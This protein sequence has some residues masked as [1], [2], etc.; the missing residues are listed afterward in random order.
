MLEKLEGPDGQDGPER[1]QREPHLLVSCI[2]SLT[3]TH[4]TLY[5]SV[6]ILCDVSSCRIRDPSKSSVHLVTS[7]TGSTRVSL[8]S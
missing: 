1:C 8:C 7:L 5:S 2:L 3:H 4:H 6:L